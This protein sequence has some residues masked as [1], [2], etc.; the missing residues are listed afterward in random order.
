MINEVRFGYRADDVPVTDNNL[1]HVQVRAIIHQIF[2]LKC[3]NCAITLLS[4]CEIMIALICG[5]F[6]NLT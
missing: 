3:K 4:A 1:L 5:F 2:K 6:P